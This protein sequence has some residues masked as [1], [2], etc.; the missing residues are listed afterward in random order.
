MALDLANYQD[1]VTAAV[2]LFWQT[3]M[4][5][6]D[7]RANVVQG[8][9]LDGFIELITDLTTANGLDAS[10]VR[11]KGDVIL[12]GY[13]RATKNWDVIVVH[14]GNLVAAFEFK[15]QVG[16][17]FG[18]NFN[19]RLEEALGS[20][21]DLWTAFRE[22]AFGVTPRPFLGYLVLLE[23]C[24]ASRRPVKASEPHFPV[25]PE[26][27]SASYLERYKLLCE[28]LVT[29]RVYDSATLLFSERTAASNGAYEEHYLHDF[30]TSF[31]GHVATAAS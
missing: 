10:C 5:S 21:T 20:A 22:E 26:F 23:D 9:H 8:K 27:R 4:G 3:R 14:E 25:F 13:F 16:P 11:S 1:K 29:E 2:R 6:G 7:N 28:K 31:A 18:N 17:S 12:P 30:V 19:N 15:S 24:E